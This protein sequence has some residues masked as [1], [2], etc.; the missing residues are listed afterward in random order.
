MNEEMS[1]VMGRPPV[2]HR[3]A[4]RVGIAPVV[5]VDPGVSPDG[6]VLVRGWPPSSQDPPRDAMPPVIP[7]GIV[8]PDGMPLMKGHP[9]SSHRPNK[10]RARSCLTI[11]SAVALLAI[12][13]LLSGA[14]LLQPSSDKATGRRGARISPRDTR[15]R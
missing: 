11:S 1:P 10:A 9:P 2:S 8:I 13:L 4:P 6:V 3:D 15:S 14:L 12:L 5:R 7:D